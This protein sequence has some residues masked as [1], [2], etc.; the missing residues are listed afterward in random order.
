MSDRYYLSAIAQQ[1]RHAPTFGEQ[2]LWYELRS[3][4]LG[5]TFRRQ[6]PLRGFIVDFYAS[7]AKLIVEVDGGYHRQ[8]QLADARR[9][10]I[11]ASHGFRVLRLADELVVKRRDEAVARVRAAL[12]RG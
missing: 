7:T 4:K 3:A 6:V 8:R 1:L 9:D 2:A 12:G 5:V 11:L 10:R